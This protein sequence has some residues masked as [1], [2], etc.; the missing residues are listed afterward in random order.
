MENSEFILGVAFLFGAILGWWLRGVL[1]LKREMDRDA[2]A[3]KQAACLHGR[4]YYD[5]DE[6]RPWF[7]WVC[8]DCGSRISHYPVST[9]DYRV[10]KP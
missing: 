10:D 4:R 7:P 5:F 9:Q 2:L 1:K 6:K 8:S 3:K